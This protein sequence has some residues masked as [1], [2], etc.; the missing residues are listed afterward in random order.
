[1]V[2]QNANDAYVCI[3][4]NGVIRDWNQQAEQTFGWSSQE[5]IGRRLDEMII[6]VTMREAHRAGLRHYSATGEHNVLNRR[7]ELTAVRRDGTLLPVEVRVSPLSIDGK[8]IFSAF[9]HDITERKQVE[10]I[11]EHGQHMTH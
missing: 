3:D 7:K 5:A 9:L 11:R 1:M 8:T 4:H 10:A 6:P 2:L